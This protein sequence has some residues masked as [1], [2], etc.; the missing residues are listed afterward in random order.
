MMRDI[1]EIYGFI[2][3]DECNCGGTLQESWQHPDYNRLRV[4][5]RPNRG[6]F[7]LW[8]NRPRIHV[9]DKAINFERELRSVLLTIKSEL[10]SSRQTT[11]E[12]CLP[13]VPK[14]E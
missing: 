7:E 4:D 12:N 14:G 13:A 2:K 10:N 6:S 1:L 8:Y 3:M 9:V 5:I 11:D